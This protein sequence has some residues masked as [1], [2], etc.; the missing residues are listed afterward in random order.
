[1]ERRRRATRYGAS[2]IETGTDD[3]GV[4][5]VACFGAS[6]YRPTILTNE[7]LLFYQERHE[8]F[9]PV[10]RNLNPSQSTC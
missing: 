4:E 1:M 3:E 8:R 10:S 6:Y 5:A 9:L 2:G 7:Q